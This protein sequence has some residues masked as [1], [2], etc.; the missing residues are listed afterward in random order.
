[1]FLPSPSVK[2]VKL[3]HAHACVHVYVVIGNILC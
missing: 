2:H 3:T 1:M